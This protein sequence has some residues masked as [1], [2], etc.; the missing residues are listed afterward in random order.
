MV[1]PGT[2]GSSYTVAI[3]DPLEARFGPK[4]YRIWVDGFGRGTK[5]ILRGLKSIGF[6]GAQM[7]KQVVFAGAIAAVLIAGPRAFAQ[8]RQSIEDAEQAKAQSNVQDPTANASV[9]GNR[10]N[11]CA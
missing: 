9:G 7:M 8:N 6:G 2:P 1:V 5:H 11:A 10:S 4:T 3:T